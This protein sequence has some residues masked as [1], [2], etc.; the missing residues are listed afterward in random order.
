MELEV[1][2]TNSAFAKDGLTVSML[3][4]M[5]DDEAVLIEC[6]FPVFQELLRRNLAG[7]IKTVLLSH[8]HQDH[9]GSAVALIEYRYNVLGEKT[10]VG[11]IDWTDLLKL[12]DGADFADMILPL[13]EHLRVE[14]ID[15]PHAKGMECR[16]LCINE[17]LF[18]SGDTSVSLLDTPLAG[19][20]EI[21]FHDA[22]K[23]GNAGH[24]SV[25][26]LAQAEPSV[27]AKTWLTHYLPQDYEL[28]S[29]KAKEAGL[30]GAARSSQRFKI[31]F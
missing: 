13:P 1:L 21:I 14:T 24:V 31:N 16:A 22:H 19:K 20:A 28:M 27:K 2:G 4:W 3:L 9:A 26:G 29:R 23:T 30:A 25:H 6:G 17:K 15:V 10:A 11:G 7:K 12:C 8:T 18:Y 5:S